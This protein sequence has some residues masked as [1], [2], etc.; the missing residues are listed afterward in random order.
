MTIYDSSCQK[1]NDDFENNFDNLMRRIESNDLTLTTLD[2]QSKLTKQQIF[3]LF[4][5]L[6][7]NHTLVAL[8]LRGNLSFDGYDLSDEYVHS[9]LAKLLKN[10]T[11]LVSLILF[12]TGIDNN[13][14]IAL[15]Y[16]LKNHNQYL[17]N[18][19]ICGHKINRDGILFLSSML[20]T[21]KT[22]EKLSVDYD[23]INGME[24]LCLIA[25]LPEISLLKLEV[26]GN[27]SSL[28]LQYI[29]FKHTKTFLGWREEAL[30]RNNPLEFKENY[31]K[32]Q[33]ERLLSL[34]EHHR[35]DNSFIQRIHH[36][37][38]T[39]EEKEQLLIKDYPSLKHEAAELEKIA[40]LHQT[41]NHVVRNEMV[42][43]YKEDIEKKRQ[44]LVKSYIDLQHQHINYLR[45]LEKVFHQRNS[46]KIEKNPVQN[47]QELDKMSKKEK[48]K[49]PDKLEENKMPKKEAV[50]NKVKADELPEE[51]TKKPT[52]LI[53]FDNKRQQNK[54]KRRL[55]INAMPA[56][57]Y[58][59]TWTN[60]VL[61]DD[62]NF[63][64]IS[65]GGGMVK[66]QQI[67]KFSEQIGN[68][69]VLNIDTFFSSEEMNNESAHAETAVN[70][71]VHKL[72]SQDGSNQTLKDNI[73]KLIQS[74]KKVI[75][76]SHVSP[77]AGIYV[78]K[79]ILK[80]NVENYGKNFLF[81]ASYFEECSTF[82][83]SKN[84]IEECVL[85]EKADKHVIYHQEQG[86]CVKDGKEIDAVGKRFAQFGTIFKSLQDISG[87]DIKSNFKNQYG[88][89]VK[90]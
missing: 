54:E 64:V 58:L 7:N 45:D 29:D 75:L 38:N 51:E 80:E 15:S 14:A 6:K 73:A 83:C 87:E 39:F 53:G 43:K 69:A 12:D 5:A 20:T 32:T 4:K 86:F 13:G 57:E 79:D 34:L 42:K 61:S 25:Q 1:P 81:V 37:L 47:K 76:L 9:K 31:K 23:G 55:I 26:S 52:L 71:L 44:E 11:R 67:P 88:L 90:S 56:I 35:F 72:N 84:F 22:L 46:V 48:S 60:A 3:A 74:G 41:A 62:Y 24:R 70:Y 85:P 21:N 82:V 40:N 27:F 2:I 59:N 68:T 17:K 19:K 16:V 78:F 10:N 49:E 77:Y 36:I 65:V 18:L 50:V 8:T 30:Y 33:K 63:A 89:G 66:G 28:L